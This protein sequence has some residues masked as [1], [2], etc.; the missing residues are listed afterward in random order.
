LTFA[1][2]MGFLGGL[3]PAIRASRLPIAPALRGL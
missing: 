3:F 1:A 2:F